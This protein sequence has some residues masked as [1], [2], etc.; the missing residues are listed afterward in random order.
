MQARYYTLEEARQ[1]MPR[2]KHLMTQVQEA[3]SEIM[4]LRPDV[5]PALQNAASNGGNVAAGEMLSHFRRLEAGVKGIMGMGV[6]VK[7][8]D[9][10]LVDFLSV[11]DGREIYLC[12]K[13]G[14]E[15]LAYWHDLNAG[16]QGRR[17]IHDRDF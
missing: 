2:V 9:M 12:W 16:Y 8:I 15:E 4:R 14:E 11:R 13:Y 6:L 3:R 17:P 10:G 7:D 1:A 5:W